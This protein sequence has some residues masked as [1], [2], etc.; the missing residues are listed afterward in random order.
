MKSISIPLLKIDTF[1][2]LASYQKMIIV[3]FCLL[4]L[5]VLIKCVL[6][7]KSFYLALVKGIVLGEPRKKGPSKERVK[8]IQEE[9]DMGANRSRERSRQKNISNV[10]MSQSNSSFRTNY[11]FNSESSQS[12]D[13]LD[14]IREKKTSTLLGKREWEEPAVSIRLA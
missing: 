9:K 10:S 13:M 2:L 12:E 8:E 14:Y 11:L 3:S 7:V 5:L 4:A 1:N 6:I